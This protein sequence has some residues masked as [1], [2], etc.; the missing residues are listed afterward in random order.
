MSNSMRYI[1]PFR[2]HRSSAWLAL[3]MGM[4]L[5]KAAAVSVDYHAIPLKPDP[6][7]AID[8]LLG[9]WQ[10]LPGSW[11]LN[12]VDRATYNKAKWKYA[13]DL[14]A[15]VWFA[16]RQENL[17]VAAEVTD[18]KFFQTQRGR[19]MYLGD[20]L[21]LNVDT[22][23]EA[24]KQRQTFGEGQFVIALSPGNFQQ[25]GDAFSDI[26]PEAF[27]YVPSNA[28]AR[29]IAVA[30]QRTE[31]GY[32]VEAAIPWK[33]LGVD[34]AVIGR[35]IT[36][37]FAVSDC[38]SAEPSQ[39]KMMTLL[40]DEWQRARGRMVSFVLSG[41][42]GKVPD[43]ASGIA[44][45]ESLQLK[46][47]EDKA[48]IIDLPALPAGREAVLILRA[49]LD[50]KQP[51]GFNHRM[52]VTLNGKA[53][54][55]KRL[56][57]KELSMEANDG[58]FFTMASGENFSVF[59]GPGYD[60][61][62]QDRG[63][64]LKKGQA[65]LFEFRVTDLVKQGA[66]TL[67]VE[68]RREDDKDYDLHA[69]SCG[70][71]FRTPAKP[72]V[73]R[74]P[75]IGSLP[76]IEPRLPTKTPF[77]IKQSGNDI[78]VSIGQEKFLVTSTFSSPAPAW[79][80][81]S[82]AYFS[83]RR[84][85]EKLDEAVVVRDSFENL[86]EENLP[87][88]HRHSI[89]VKG[90]KKAWVAGLSP[91][92]SGG[93]AQN[94]GN[95]TTV[96]VTDKSAIGLLPLEDVLRVHV[97]N[98]VDNETLGLA[99]N[100]LVLKPNTKYT[101]EWAVVVTPAP[102]YYAF[103]NAARRLL[104]VNFTIDGGFSFLTFRPNDAGSMN[105]QQLGDYLRF[106]NAKFLSNS[107]LTPPYKSLYTMHSPAYQL[108]DHSYER[109]QLTRARKVAP[110]AKHLCYFH[111]FLD[112]L[113][114]SAAN[115]AADR[116]L[117]SDGQHA[118]YAGREYM[119][120]FVPTATNVWGR[121]IAKNISFA[122]DTV[123]YD[124]IYWDETE[125]SAY[126]YHY[127]G[128]WDG[129]S[130]DIDPRSMRIHRL[131]SSVTLISQ[132]YRLNLARKLL[133][134]KAPLIG[135]GAPHTQS[136]NELHFPRFVETGSISNCVLAHLYTPIALGDHITERTEVDA[137]NWMLKALDYGCVYYWYSNT[138]RPT[139]PTLTRYRFPITPVELHAG[140]IIGKERILTNRSGLYGWGDKS[141]HEV[142][143]FDDQGNE[144][145]GIQAPTVT[146]NGKTYTELR[147]GEG[148][149]AAVVRK[150]L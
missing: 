5:G 6:P 45:F 77:T 69:A 20:H 36:L 121:D 142:H 149:S 30:S 4:C 31:T 116:L 58:R 22:T 40:T 110:E 32:T 135:N 83:F 134:L 27:V 126:Q 115:Y 93:R 63:Y 43:I 72:R 130:A 88:M 148:W 127:G 47:E 24:D 38:D 34:D 118:T 133:D 132:E 35:R 109:E 37:E 54:D 92:G 114:E 96:G 144:V 113:P 56:V 55:A 125:Y 128:P 75:P 1:H 122:M 76:V 66:N 145:P 12:S 100:Q 68:N 85:I 59:F 140:Y 17:Y 16:W 143:V 53:L 90:L 23:P 25:T 89:Q 141:R 64:G 49:R 52:R 21:E 147:I 19:G 139:H 137:Y 129:V 57:N 102:D 136:M 78:E 65:S 15:K 28:S 44:V 7:F 112:E 9:E 48:F 117:L 8:G 101:T 146:R 74:G 51:A 103:V 73:K 11:P 111:C 14:S 62:D 42:D 67:V 91:S 3:L 99:D 124:G 97:A 71:E 94:P 79:V 150:G 123:G 104:K 29:E 107:Y 98:L 87:L 131:K 10:A 80:K 84:D 26:G 138:V 108:A 41:S 81:G 70:F 2:S 46:S 95:P 119:K 60:A 50:Y 61:I 86:T 33:A 106:K 82:N 120:I 13:T 39:D 18:D 105:D